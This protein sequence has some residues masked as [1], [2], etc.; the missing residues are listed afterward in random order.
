MTP[1]EQA[2]QAALAEQVRLLAQVNSLEQ[3]LR[4]ALE[5]E[6][7][8]KG[9]IEALDTELENTKTEN[10]HNLQWAVEMTK[11][12]NNVGMFVSDALFKAREEI[13]TH[14]GNGKGIQQAYERV[15]KAL[16]ITQEVGHESVQREGER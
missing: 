1:L 15:E 3:E 13:S 16:S 12:L 10:R 8:L 4:A 9:R 2:T 14:Q 6:N 11:Q 5:R 7:I